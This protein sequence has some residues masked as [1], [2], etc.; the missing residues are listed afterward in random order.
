LDS[1]KFEIAEECDCAVLITDHLAKS[2]PGQ[3]ARARGAGAKVDWASLVINL[4]H[5]RTPE[6]ESGRFIAADVTK[7]R[8]GWEPSEP[9]ILRRSQH[10]LR[11]SIWEPSHSLYID[12]IYQ[13]LMEEG[14]QVNSQRQMLQLIR[15]RLNVGDRLAR[16]FLNSAIEQ[17]IE[18]CNGRNNSIIYRLPDQSDS[19][20]GSNGDED[21]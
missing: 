18:T 4:S 6:G 2:D 7:M 15:D 11:H 19:N 8:Y 13:V 21:R 20:H 12:Q 10:S 1:I 5:H 17:G 9:I 14:R 3:G 16:R